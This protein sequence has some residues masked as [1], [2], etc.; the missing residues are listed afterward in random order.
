MKTGYFST[1]EMDYGRPGGDT[2]HLERGEIFELQ[3]TPND[4]VLIEG[5]YIV[6]I[7]AQGIEVD[8]HDCVRC[9]KKFADA[10]YKHGH[11]TGQNPCGIEARGEDPA[12]EIKSGE[13]VPVAAMP[14]EQTN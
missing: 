12:V 5:N 9:N 14:G 3:M 8:P 11:D 13:P 2:K 6:D 4:R 10:S 1:R 7:K